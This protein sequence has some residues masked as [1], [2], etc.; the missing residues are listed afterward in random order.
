MH[1]EKVNSELVD[2]YLVY[3]YDNTAKVFD[4]L[5]EA[6]TYARNQSSASYRIFTYKA[7][8][9]EKAIDAGRRLP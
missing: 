3:F 4:T 5:E 6:E 1:W 2:L 9:L 8:L 7:T